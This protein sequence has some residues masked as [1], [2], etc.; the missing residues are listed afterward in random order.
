MNNLRDQLNRPL[1]LAGIAFV[2]GMIFGL[3]VLGWWLWPVQWTDAS[4]QHLRADLQEDYLRMAIDSYARNPNPELA[5]QRLA[6]LGEEAKPALELI[7]KNNGGQ[8]P[9]V[10]GEFD[11]LLYG[12]V[13]AP[14]ATLPVE[15][16]AEGVVVPTAALPEV[17]P[18]AAA[19]RSSLTLILVLLCVLTLV[20][21]AV[22]LYLFVFRNRQTQGSAT[23]GATIPRSARSA[24]GPAY[25]EATPDAPVVQYLSTYTLGND[26][27]DDSFSIDSPTGEFLGECGVGISETIGVGDPKKV[28]AFEVWLFDKN[29]IQ[30]VTKV[31]MST[32]AFN[33]PV[34]S[35]RL[36][37]KGEPMLAEPGKRISLETATLQ[38]EARVVSMSYGSGALPANSYFE[39]ITLELAVWPKQPVL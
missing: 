4:P 18:A 23:A 6:E 35:Q 28:T 32:H 7:K 8:D 20:I 14:L 25:A 29:D 5:K 2:V 31:V 9:A 19:P 10:I 13:G 21:A 1:V 24:A 34:I 26:L 33:D 12:E 15:T 30:T 3:V 37:S 16:P 11:R 27:Y 17:T 22:L 36:A 38:L 39:Q